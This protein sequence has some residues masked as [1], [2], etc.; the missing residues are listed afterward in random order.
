MRRRVLAALGLALLAGGTAA[1]ASPRRFEELRRFQAEAARQGVAVDASAFYAISNQAIEKYDKTT[2][3]R[4]ASWTG[5]TDGPIVHLN[6]AVAHEGRLY[7][8]HSNHPGVPM[9]SSIEIFDTGDLRHLESR[10]FG[11]FEGSAT[12]VDRHDGAWWVG[13]AQYQGRGGVPGRGP[14]WTSVVAF[15]DSWQRLEAFVFP[16]AVIARFGDRSNS[17]GAWGDDGLLYATGA[18]LPELYALRRPR[19]GSVLELVEILTVTAT[20]QGLAWDPARPDVLFT[21]LKGAR[22]VVESRLVLEPG[23]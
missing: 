4:L 20:G 5:P 13:F 21:I 18:D 11:I 16:P 9:W 19:A 10:S 7:C 3:E 1:E 15:D 23:A 22:Q 2:G 17:G 6:G 12:W 8:A 14:A